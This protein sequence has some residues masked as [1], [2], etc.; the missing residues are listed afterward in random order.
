MKKILIVAICFLLLV[1]SYSMGCVEEGDDEQEEDNDDNN[2]KDDNNGSDNNGNNTTLDPEFDLTVISNTAHTP[3]KTSSHIAHPNEQTQFLFLLKNTG[4]VGG[5][6]QMDMNGPESGWKYYLDGVEGNLD[7]DNK[8]QIIQKGSEAMILTV[9]VPNIGST[10]IEITARSI[11][12][13]SQTSTVEV[14]VKVNDL[15]NETSEMGNQVKVYYTLVDRG[16][17]GDYNENVWRWNQAG[18]FPF[19]IG[20]GTIQGFVDISLGM[21]EGETRVWLLPEDAC[22]GSDPQDGKPDGPLIFEVT[23]LD[24]NYEY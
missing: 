7:Q 1:S 22:Y 8:L 6:Y 24:L 17:D 15:G 21:R 11:E 3:E 9:K 10:R 14:K 5:T 20:E 23:M 18:E 2:K 13:P 12:H 19:T 4:D 16:T